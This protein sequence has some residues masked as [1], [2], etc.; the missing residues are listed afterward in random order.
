MTQPTKQK[1]PAPTKTQGAFH[2]QYRRDFTGQLT[3]RQRIALN[4]LL[5]GPVSREALDRVAGCSNGPELIA[6]LRRMGFQI[7]CQRVKKID[8]YGHVCH[9]GVYSLSVY[10]RLVLGGNTC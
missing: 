7:P 2:Y 5:Q 3:Q 9:P 10:D 8:R 6:E 4:A 1:A